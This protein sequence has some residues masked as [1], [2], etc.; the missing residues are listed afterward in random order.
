MDK[1][2]DDQQFIKKAIITKFYH[3][4]EVI[5]PIKIKEILRLIT[6][7]WYFEIIFMKKITLNFNSD[8]LDY[9]IATPLNMFRE[10][11]RRFSEV[12]TVGAVEKQGKLISVFSPWIFKPKIY[13][14][15]RIYFQSKQRIFFQTNTWESICE[16]MLNGGATIDFY[17]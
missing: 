10:N 3:H 8:S 7:L 9:H 6:H 14:N 1:V 13:W 5:L 12:F 11:I 4:S 16:N 2:F 17:W 15:N